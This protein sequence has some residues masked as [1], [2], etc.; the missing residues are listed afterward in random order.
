MELTD[1]LLARIVEDEETARAANGPRWAAGDGNVSEG[2][3]YALQGDTSDGWTIAWFE[4]GTANEAKDGGRQLPRWP[5][6]ERYAQENADHAARHDPARVLRECEAKRRIVKDAQRN[7]NA[8]WDAYAIGRDDL[9]RQVL[10]SLAAVY[11]DHPD[12]DPAW[13]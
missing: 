5:K 7:P 8:S 2:G 6:M 4:L 9:A 3:L 10:R 11:T 12:F 13:A 1:F